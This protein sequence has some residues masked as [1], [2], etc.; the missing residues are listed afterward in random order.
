MTSPTF[1]SKL[2]EVSNSMKKAM[3]DQKDATAGSCSFS[4]KL[5]GM[6]VDPDDLSLS[7]SESTGD[8]SL[9]DSSRSSSPD[10]SI[11]ATCGSESVDDD[12]KEESSKGSARRLSFSESQDV[13]PTEYEGPGLCDNNHDFTA[14]F[15]FIRRATRRR[16][17][18]I[19]KEDGAEDQTSAMSASRE[20][21]S[22]YY[23]WRPAKPR[24]AMPRSNFFHEDVAHKM[25][26]ASDCSEHESDKEVDEECEG[27]GDVHFRRG[28]ADKSSC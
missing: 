1:I 11:H 21:L 2:E 10:T 27:S 19:I 17:A 26:A 7:D 13:G 14:T 9:Q 20:Y 6:S 23:G 25:I 5:A 24:R 22:E 4:P 15:G 28:R 3:T 16:K 18:G 8:D 12:P